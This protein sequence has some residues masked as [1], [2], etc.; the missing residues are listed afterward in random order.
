MAILYEFSFGMCLYAK[1]M[2]P[3]GT[4][5]ET[6]HIGGERGVPEAVP[7]GPVLAM[8][9]CDRNLPDAAPEKCHYC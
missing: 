9:P 6:F 5:A 4:G 3:E 2:P 7:F 1:A 8:A